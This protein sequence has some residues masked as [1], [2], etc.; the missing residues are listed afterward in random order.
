MSHIPVNHRLRPFYRT[1]AV[2]IGLYLLIFGIIGAIQTADEPFFSRGDTVVLGLKTNLAFS[3]LSIVMGAIVL[4]ANLYGRNVDHFVDMVA[5][6]VFMF[7]G[8][9]GL[10]I[11]R[12]DLN[13]LNFSVATCVVSSLI[14]TVLLTTGFYNRTG[15]MEQ[16]RQEEAIRVPG[17]KHP[18]PAAA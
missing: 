18:G 7:V 17:G 14:G 8:V 15:P 10:I 13:K 4:L 6:G 1:L 16:A 2:L 12:S 3:I 11:I 5:G 9:F